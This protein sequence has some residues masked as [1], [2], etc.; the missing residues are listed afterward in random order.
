[1]RPFLVFASSVNAAWNTDRSP[2]SLLS[3]D[4][5]CTHNGDLPLT[6]YPTPDSSI[7]VDLDAPACRRLINHAFSPHEVVSLI[8]TIFT[9]QDEIK[10]IGYLRGDNAQTF[11]DVI[12]D[13][14]STL[15]YCKYCGLI[16]TAG[17]SL[18]FG[19]P[20]PLIRLWI[21]MNSHHGSGGNV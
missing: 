19:S 16:V 4:D 6:V 2:Q 3:R 17:S 7:L 15:V 5:T 14:R 9:S 18:L 20:T 8:E 10:M 12:H 1:M 21:F 13:V 11:I